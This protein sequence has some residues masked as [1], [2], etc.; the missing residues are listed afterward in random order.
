VR[1]ANG[2]LQ[3]WGW[4]ADGR[5]GD[6]TFAGRDAPVD[7]LGFSSKPPTPLPTPTPTEGPLTGDAD[8]DGTVD[9]I[10]AAL[11]LQRTAA[12]IPTLPCASLADADGNGEIDSRDAALIL[13]LAAGLISTLPH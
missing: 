11:V 1:R 9:A 6:G 10:D 4:N 7:V 12:L 3:C 8:C 5:L 2:A 13:Q